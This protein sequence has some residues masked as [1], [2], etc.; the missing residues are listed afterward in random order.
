MA[1]PS[2]TTGTE[3][4]MFFL[5]RVS[6]LAHRHTRLFNLFTRANPKPQHD[7]NHMQSLYAET[8]P[9]MPPTNA[10]ASERTSERHPYMHARA[11]F[12]SAQMLSCPGAHIHGLWYHLAYPAHRFDLAYGASVAISFQ[13]TCF[14]Q[15]D[16]LLWVWRHRMVQRHV[17]SGFTLSIHRYGCY[18]PL[19]MRGQSA[20]DPIYSTARDTMPHQSGIFRPDVYDSERG[21]SSS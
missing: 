6:F 12:A 17:R 4:L 2:V 10:R 14:F 21:S 19:A 16:L 20:A 9:P 5:L 11:W 3:A 18:I 1:S 15:A 7:I 13:R 8:Q